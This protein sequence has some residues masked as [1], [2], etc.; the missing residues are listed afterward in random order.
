M[1]TNQSQPPL[2][3]VDHGPLLA[4]PGNRDRFLSSADSRVSFSYNQTAKELPTTKK[5][6]RRQLVFVLLLAYC[7]FS[8]A[9]YSA[10]LA[11]FFPNEGEKRGLSATQYGA[12]IGTIAFVIF[13]SSP[14]V[15]KLVSFAKPKSLI[16]TGMFV[17]G[18]CG[19]L[20]GFLDNSPPGTTLFVLA[21][22]V[23]FVAGLGASVVYN[24][25]Y[26]IMAKEV[27]DNRGT[28]TSLLEMAYGVGSMLSPTVGGV[29][30]EF[31][32][33]KAP[34]I[35]LGTA[36]LI[37]SVLVY[38]FLPD[39]D[40]ESGCSM[41]EILSMSLHFGFALD[42][43]I[44]MIAISAIYFNDVTLEP[45]L[46]QFDLQPSIV[47]IVFV[48][49]AFTYA[50]SAPI[51]GWF[52]DKLPNIRVTYPVATLACILCFLLISPAP[53]FHFEPQLWIIILSLFLLGLGAEGQTICAFNNA[54]VE[55]VSR[56]YPAN[57]TTFSMVSAA[58][59]SMCALG[60][61]LGAIAGGLLTDYVGYISGTVFMVVVETFLLVLVVGKLLLDRYRKI[62]PKS[63]TETLLSISVK[64]TSMK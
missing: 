50:C 26:P 55:T 41:K 62:G 45:H 59:N 35:F 30:Y 56:G 2:D 24:F 49:A 52:C 36:L 28:A 13:I 12:I 25:G 33:F 3:T 20:F 54:L 4:S 22:A 8:M 14:I 44:C 63:E 42:M 27:V 34:F 51:W 31:G 61:F 57:V 48:S 18:I 15:P 1:A 10:L 16:N 9:L 58:F 7:Y 40:T 5:L 23:Q 11:P 60:S 47:G 37:G 64:K 32:G 29:L 43:V 6:S 39:S 21:L 53:F 17:S 38:F 19:I 46:R